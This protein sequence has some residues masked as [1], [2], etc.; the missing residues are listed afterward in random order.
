MANITGSMRVDRVSYYNESW[1]V[2]IGYYQINYTITPDYIRRKYIVN[3]KGYYYSYDV[4]GSAVSTSE[5]MTFNRIIEHNRPADKIK[6]G[7]NSNLQVNT[8]NYIGEVT[9]E[10]DFN[11]DGT[12]PEL[13]ICLYANDYENHRIV[14]TIS[15]IPALKTSS[16][17]VNG[18][19][20][21]AFIWLKCNGIWKRCTIWK[22]I[23]G[24]WKKS[25]GR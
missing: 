19:W 20:Y 9:Q 17:K 14:Q 25:S 18:H 24:V 15:N 23:S 3:V 11:K 6:I 4:E 1:K 16:F 7:T 8:L 22:K 5:Y 21:D 12:A 10:F 2:T 13:L